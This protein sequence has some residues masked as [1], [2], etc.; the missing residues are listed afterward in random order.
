[1]TLGRY[2]VFAYNRHEI[3]GGWKD[4]LTGFDDPERARAYINARR[5]EFD[6]IDAIDSRTGGS[7]CPVK[8]TQAALHDYRVAWDAYVKQNAAPPPG[9]SGGA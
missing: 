1:M 6:E 9:G 2:L 5:A 7:I 4:F 3:K 8:I